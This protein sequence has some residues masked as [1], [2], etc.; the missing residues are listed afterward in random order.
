MKVD[1][2]PQDP[3]IIKDGRCE[4]CYAVDRDGSYVLY[5]SK[6]WT[7]KNIANSQAWDVINNRIRAVA[8]Q[9]RKGKESPL[10]FYMVQHQMDV[11]L[12]AKYAGISRWRVRRH[13]KPAVFEKLGAR[14]LSRYADLFEISVD[15]IKRIPNDFNQENMT[16][17]DDKY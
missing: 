7:P 9:V 11:R 1:E 4:I 14:I 6:G 10:A 15:Q 2:V 5:G 16:P 8:E 13:L 17:S 12:L 3:G